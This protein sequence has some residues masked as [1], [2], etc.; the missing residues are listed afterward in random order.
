MLDRFVVRG[1]KIVQMDV[2]ERQRGAPADAQTVSMPR[3]RRCARP[4]P[5]RR[6]RSIFVRIRAQ[7]IP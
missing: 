3:L 4:L 1:G 2:L 7:D 6:R 5:F